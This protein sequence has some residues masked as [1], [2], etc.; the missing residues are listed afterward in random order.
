MAACEHL[1]R[2]NADDEVTSYPDSDPPRAP[3]SCSL[4]H[5]SLTPLWIFLS[6]LVRSTLLSLQLYPHLSKVS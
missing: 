5:L 4:S 6:V 2:L 1:L 3:L